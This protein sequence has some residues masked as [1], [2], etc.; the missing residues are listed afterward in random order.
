MSETWTSTRA[1]IA[2]S[3][4]HHPEADT[5]VLERDHRAARAEEYVRK[6]VDGAPALTDAQRNQ[7]ALLLR[8]GAA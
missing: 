5:T 4:R 2:A 3:K 8:P 1:R 6:L 7:L